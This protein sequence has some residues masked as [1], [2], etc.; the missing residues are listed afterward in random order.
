ME[1]YN[2]T[3]NHYTNYYTNGSS[4]EGVILYV[5]NQSTFTIS[6][7]HYTHNVGNRNIYGADHVLIYARNTQ[8]MFNKV[9]PLHPSKHEGS[10]GGVIARQD[11]C[12]VDI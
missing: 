8:F 7:S 1:K 3:E 4:V 6:D 2:L 12:T 9:L 11:Y 10:E 5:T